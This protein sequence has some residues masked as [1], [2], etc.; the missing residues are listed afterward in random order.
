MAFISRRHGN[1]V[2]KQKKGLFQNTFRS[3]CHSGIL[4][5]NKNVPS[6]IFS[7]PFVTELV[8]LSAKGVEIK[9]PECACVSGVLG[10]LLTCLSGTPIISHEWPVFTHV[11]SMLFEFF[12]LKIVATPNKGFAPFTIFPL[13]SSNFPPEH[14]TP[15]WQ[16]REILSMRSQLGKLCIKS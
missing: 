12:W 5:W 11:I 2:V 15:E 16:I 4:W 9:V 3:V 10:Y 14:V 7:A 1:P 6:R 8:L 13:Y